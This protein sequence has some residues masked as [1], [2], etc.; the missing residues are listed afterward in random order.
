MI[1][2]I[3]QASVILC[4]YSQERWQDLVAAVDSIRRQTTP[5]GE[6]IVV[7]D[8]NRELYKMALAQF[9]DIRVVEN[10]EQQGLSGARNTG[11]NNARFPVV[12]FM[13]DD[14]T[15]EKDWLSCLLSS[16][17]D[18]R[19]MGIGGSVEPKWLEQ[20]PGWFPDEFAWVVGC[21]YKGLPET[22]SPVRNMMGCNMSFKRDMFIRAGGFR[23][24]LGRSGGKFL[25]S[26]EETEFCIRAKHYFPGS[27]FIYEPRAR[28][29]HK[30]PAARS[31]W[32]Y[33]RS[34]CY[35]EGLSKAWVANYVGARDG[36]ASERKYTLQ[37]LPSGILRRI[38]SSLIE[39]HRT[40]LLQAGAILAGLAITSMGYFI[41]QFTTRPDLSRISL[42]ESS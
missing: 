38:K 16:Y 8:H 28:I 25:I 1:D 35:A 12:T 13:D 22:T 3:P 9:P 18:E 4:A 20:P 32:S 41:G 17:R 14:A 37:T 30:V 26:C 15:A 5:A 42:P 2:P 36:L 6:I 11:V 31:T 39:G 34:R 23:P 40:G 19:V 29:H 33:Y 27:Q 10:T 7:I 24:T 21:A